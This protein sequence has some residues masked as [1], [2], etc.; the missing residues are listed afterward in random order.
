M[1]FFPNFF[2]EP[3]EEKPDQFEQLQIEIDPPVVEKSDK[4]EEETTRVIII[5]L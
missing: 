5:Q 3:K 4:K 1:N 2:Y